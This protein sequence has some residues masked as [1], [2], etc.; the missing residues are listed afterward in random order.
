MNSIILNFD[1]NTDINAVYNQLKKQYP[2]IEIIRNNDASEN[3]LD[4]ENHKKFIKAVI[5]LNGLTVEPKLTFA[6]IE[7]Y[8]KFLDDVCGSID[9]PTMVE[10]DEIE[11]ESPRE[12]II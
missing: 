11:Y 6:T 2:K 4:P 10:P 9:D 7:E 1:D 3:T 8:H 12:P 5:E